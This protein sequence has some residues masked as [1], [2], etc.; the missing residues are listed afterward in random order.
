MPTRRHNPHDP[1]AVMSSK[2][3]QAELLGKLRHLEGLVE[4][5]SAQVDSEPGRVGDEGHSAPSAG[6][7]D[8]NARDHGGYHGGQESVGDALRPLASEQEAT[9]DLPVSITRSFGKLILGRDGSYYVGNRLW[10]VLASEVKKVREALEED[11]QSSEF[12]PDH[13][14]NEEELVGANLRIPFSWDLGAFERKAAQPLPSQVPFIWQVFQENVDVLVKV[15]HV[16][17][18][19]QAIKDSK[20]TSI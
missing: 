12:I 16:P 1:N 4:E 10:G 9:D 7:S 19:T 18:V 8:S 3:K 6:V 20:G 14:L 15:I 17:S 2:R 5:L 11:E 13:L